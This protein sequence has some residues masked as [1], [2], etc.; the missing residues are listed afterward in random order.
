VLSP[1]SGLKVQGIAVA[2]VEMVAQGN[3]TGVDAGVGEGAT[4]WQIKTF[5]GEF[6]SAVWLSDVKSVI[7]GCDV[8]ANATVGAVG[9]NVTIV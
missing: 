1:P 8:T 9:G 6:N 3:A 4:K 5:W 7:Q 2:E